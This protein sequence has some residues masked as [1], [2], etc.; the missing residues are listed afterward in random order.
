[1]SW[2]T[3]SKNISVIANQ[4]KGSAS[5][6]WDEATFTW[7]GAAGTWSNPFDMVNATKHTSTI[8]NATKH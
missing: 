4:A 3:T 1:M 7:A 8:S 2:S 5:L 6:T